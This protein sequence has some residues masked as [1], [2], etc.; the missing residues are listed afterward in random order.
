M[1][2]G[3]TKDAIER[4]KLPE[5]GRKERFIRDDVVRGLGVRITAARAKSFIFEAGVKGRPRRLTL[6]AWPNLTVLLARKRA[7]EIR[8]GD[9]ERRRSALRAPNRKARDDVWRTGGPVHERI[10]EAS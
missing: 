1:A 2:L 8:T 3:L 4:A 6:G 9:C 10:C 5:R 7:F